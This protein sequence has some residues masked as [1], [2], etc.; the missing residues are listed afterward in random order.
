MIMKNLYQCAR[1]G[2]RDDLE[3]AVTRIDLW[4]YD[5]TQLAGVRHHWVLT[6]WRQPSAPAI[7]KGR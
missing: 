4:I 3:A 7:K 1:A 2:V 6:A 5:G